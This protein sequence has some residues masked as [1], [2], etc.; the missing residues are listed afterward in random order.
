[1]KYSVVIPVFNE[2]D[3]LYP[4]FN[5]LKETMDSLGERYEVIFINDGSTDDTLN[6]LN[7]LKETNPQLKVINFAKNRGQGKAIEEGFCNVKGD[8]IITIDGDLQNDP[9]DIPK[10]IAK[11]NEGFN[12]V[13]GWRYIRKENLLKKAKS[14]L[15]NFLQGR[16]TQLNLH[17][18]SCTFRAYSREIINGI[19]FKRKYDFSLL[20]YIIFQRHKVKIAEVKIEHN[21][22]KSGKTKYKLLE[23]I[24]GTIYSYLKIIL[25]SKYLY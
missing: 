6:R 25:E 11:I 23:T 14:R 10:L 24:V 21:Y 8:I 12:L 13:C 16:I 2:R 15:G 1:M 20:P 3:S 18:M 9:R 19:T 5:S 17:D 7:A 4:L 22:R